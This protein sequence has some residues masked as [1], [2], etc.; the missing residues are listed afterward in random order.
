MKRCTHCKKELPDHLDHCIYCG[1]DFDIA[2][3]EMKS[4]SKSQTGEQQM[5]PKPQQAKTTAKKQKKKRN[6]GKK[7]GY[8]LFDQSWFI[9]LLL[10]FVFPLGIIFALKKKRYYDAPFTTLY[11]TSFGV[12]F[13]IQ[14]YSHYTP[15]DDVLLLLEI[16]LLFGLVFVILWLVVVILQLS[17]KRSIGY[18][19]FTIFAVCFNAILLL[20]PRDIDYT[21]L[22][23]LNPLQI[24]N[25][26][27][28]NDDEQTKST[29]VNAEKQKKKT[30]NKQEQTS[31]TILTIDPNEVGQYG[32]LESVDG[33]D[34]I[35]Y[36]L[37]EG[38]YS[39]SLKEPTD[40][41]VVLTVYEDEV[42]KKKLTIR[43]SKTNFVIEKNQ[44]FTLDGTSMV[45]FEQNE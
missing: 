15:T 14:L 36:Y 39:I 44:Y 21:K 30:T 34:E 2:S 8:S 28:K 17:V 16:W 4:S 24:W 29:S 38:S 40:S 1:W 35:H 27:Q 18:A 5:E 10:L 45:Q 33:Q 20:D 41:T 37:K 43:S 23:Q 7:K 11:A 9:F 12:L 31:K 13:W 25:N 6:T 22:M 3:K 26:T 32:V 42:S 19:T